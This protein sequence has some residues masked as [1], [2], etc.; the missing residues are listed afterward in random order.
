MYVMLPNAALKLLHWEYET[1]KEVLGWYELAMNYLTLDWE[2][3]F[4]LTSMNGDP[5]QLYLGCLQSGPCSRYSSFISLSHFLSLFEVQRFV[6]FWLTLVY[7]NFRSWLT[8]SKTTLSH[9]ME[10]NIF[11]WHLPKMVDFKDT[12]GTF[13]LQEYILLFQS[14]IVLLGLCCSANGWLWNEKWIVW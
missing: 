4:S 13:C 5:Y 9:I 7:R 14:D 2:H 10:F 1:L 11:L 12:S 8:E 3:C 6:G